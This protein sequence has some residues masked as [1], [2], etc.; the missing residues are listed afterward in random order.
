MFLYSS[1][2]EGRWSVLEWLAHIDST[3]L[4]PLQCRRHQAS[5]CAGLSFVIC[6]SHL[7]YLSTQMDC[8]VVSE[9][10]FLESRE[11][12]LLVLVSAALWCRP[13]SL[14]SFLELNYTFLAHCN[15]L[16][17]D[18]DSNLYQLR[19][20]ALPFS[21]TLATIFISYLLFKWNGI[22]RK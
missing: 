16:S 17:R 21:V 20:R 2:Y 22:S 11:H 4:R 8:W 10:S 7:H 9:F 15:V 13:V 14:Q 3:K 18:V 19:N 12:I 5:C 6:F 1:C